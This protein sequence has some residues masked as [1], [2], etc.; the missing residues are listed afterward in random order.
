MIKP[1][2]GRIIWF[3]PDQNDQI[4]RNGCEPLPA[5][6]TAVLSDTCVNLAVFDANGVPAE[7]GRQSVEILDDDTGSDGFYARWMPYQKAVASGEIPPTLHAT[8]S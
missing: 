2:V 1:T 8:K 6:V 7:G 4:A 5:I 3:Y